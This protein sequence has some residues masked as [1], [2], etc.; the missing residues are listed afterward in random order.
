MSTRSRI[1]LMHHGKALGA[2]YYFMDGHIWNFAPELLKALRETTPQSILA[3][4]LLINLMGSYAL[5]ADGERDENLDFLCE[6]D[7]SFEDY[8]IRL[9]EWHKGIVFEGNLAE[10]S[11][12][13]DKGNN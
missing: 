8:V 1:K 3:N 9:H 5:E 11:E 4:S 12:K 7:L 10:F 13:Y 2:I 6:V